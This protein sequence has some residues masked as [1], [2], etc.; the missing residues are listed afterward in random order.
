MAMSLNGVSQLL[1]Q[2]LEVLVHTL[3][4]QHHHQKVWSTAQCEKPQ[5]LPFDKVQQNKVGT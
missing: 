5:C 3:L 2:E 4:S 1:E